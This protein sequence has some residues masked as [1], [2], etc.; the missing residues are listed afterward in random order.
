MERSVLITGGGRG[1]G[2]AIAQEF[3]RLGDRVAIAQRSPCTFEQVHSIV[4]DVSDPQQVSNAWKEARNLNGPIEVL[5]NNAAIYDNMLLMGMTNEQFSRV[6]DTNL[7]GSF[8]TTRCVYS[9]MVKMKSGRIIFVSSTVAARGAEGMVNYAS[10]K[11]ALVGMARSLARE[12]GRYGITVNVIAPGL[13]ATGMAAEIAKDLGE[14]IVRETPLMRS[15]SP[16]EVSTA[17]SWLASKGAG[18]VTG[19]V[20]PVDGGWGMGY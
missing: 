20:I 16:E 18:F 9:D 17:V 11:S 12:V 3:V 14:Q 6:I 13:I 1:I 8:Y 10:S 2:A 5:V 19:A 7:S 4:C 15:G